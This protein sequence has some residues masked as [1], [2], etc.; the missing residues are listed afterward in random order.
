MGASARRRAVEE[1]SYD[2]LVTRYRDAI[3]A[4]CD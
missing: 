4:V 2:L 1:F 3:R